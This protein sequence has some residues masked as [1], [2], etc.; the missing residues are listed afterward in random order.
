M[1]NCSYVVTSRIVTGCIASIV[2]NVLA[3]CFAALSSGVRTGQFV[4]NYVCLTGGIASEEGRVVGGV[5][6]QPVA[7]VGAACL[8]GSVTIS[9]NFNGPTTIVV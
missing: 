3:G 9:G 5:V 7:S 2:V 8:N 6:S 4:N 1:S